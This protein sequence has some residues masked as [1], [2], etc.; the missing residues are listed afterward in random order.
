M[1]KKLIE[2]G[3]EGRLWD[4]KTVGWEDEGME[5]QMGR[6]VEGQRGEESEYRGTEE[7]WEE[8]RETDGH[9]D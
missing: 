9:S 1:K 3:R 4:K 7:L 2:G 5:R 8:G 6:R